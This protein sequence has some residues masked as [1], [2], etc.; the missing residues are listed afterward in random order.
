MAIALFEIPVSGCTCL[1]T[2]ADLDH[3]KGNKGGRQT[4]VDV[5]RVR[6]FAKLTPLLLFPL[7]TSTSTSSSRLGGRGSLGRLGWCLG[8][9]S[10][11]R[12]LG[13]S[14][15]WFGRH[16]EQDE[17]CVV[18]ERGRASFIMD[19]RVWRCLSLRDAFGGLVD[20]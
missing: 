3:V 5:A 19:D 17:S 14:R 20:W 4:L 6:L 9:G 12:G 16:R 7:N 13:S 10:R 1:R 8:S 18:E 15:N 2:A 11:G